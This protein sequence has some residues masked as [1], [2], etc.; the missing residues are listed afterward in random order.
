[1]LYFLTLLKIKPPLK[2]NTFT[3]SKKRFCKAGAGQEKDALKGN[4]PG[5]ELTDV[6]IIKADHKKTTRL[7]MPRNHRRVNQSSMD[8]L[9][10]W[11][12]NCDIQL[13][14][15][16][17]NPK[18]PNIG[19]IAR[20]TDYVVAYSCKGNATIQEE[21]ETNKAIALNATQQTNDKR[22]LVRLSKKIMN[23]CTK[24]RMI[25]KQEA[26][27]L[28]G[29]LDLFSCS[30]T[31]ESMSISNSKR[32]RKKEAP[33]QN[34]TFVD[35]YAKRPACMESSN[36]E[37]YFDAVSNKP[38]SSKII[39]PNF[40]GIANTPVYPP[41]ENYARYVLT[42]YKPW[43]TY[44]KCTNW[45]NVF[46]EFINSPNAPAS[47][48]IPY[49]R[50][51]M[52]Y[53]DKTVHHQPKTQQVDH[54]QNEINQDDKELLELCGLKQSDDVDYDEKVLQM[55]D[56]GLEHKWDEPAKVCRLQLYLSNFKPAL[57]L[58]DFFFEQNR[59]LV[60]PDIPPGLWLKTMIE[61][62]KKRANDDAVPES[63]SLNIPKRDDG[64][65][66]SLDLLKTDQ[67]NVFVMV[68]SKVKEFMES[69][70]LSTFTPLRA[71][72]N[73]FGGSGKSMVM[74]T[75]V[76]YMRKMFQYNDVIKIAAPTGTAAFNVGGETLHSLFN[77]KVSDH[78]LG[79]FSRKKRNTLIK[80]FKCLLAL[81]IDERSLVNNSDLGAAEQVIQEYLY[82]GGPLSKLD[83]GG[84]PILILVGDDYQ[85]PGVTEGPLFA[86]TAKGGSK[87]TY[88]GRQSVLHCA[89]FVMDLQSS[90]RLNANAMHQA[91]LLSHLRTGEELTEG[92]VTKLL[93]LHIDEVKKSCGKEYIEALQQDAVYLFYK[94]E[95]RIR[96]NF[97]MLLK[98]TGKRN[99]VAKIAPHCES[100]LA[101][102]AIRRHFD[103]DTP[104]TSFISKGAKVAIDEVNMYPMWGLHNGACGIV[105]EIIFASGQSP[106]DGNLPQYVVVNFPMYCGPTWDANNT[107]SV[108]IPIWSLT[109]NKGCCSR[110]WLPLTLAYART[111]HKFQGLTAG[112]NEPNKPPNMYKCIFCDPDEKQY[113]GTA[114]G[115]LYTA[116]SR[117][118]TLGQDN[119]K[120]SGIYF[121]GTDFKKSRIYNLYK[122]K[123]SLDDYEMAAKRKK[124]VQH[125][126]K[127][128]KDLAKMNLPTDEIIQWCKNHTSN[129]TKLDDRIS[130]YVVKKKDKKRKR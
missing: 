130:Q 61:Q 2:F 122:K 17:T 36:M 118:T 26:V 87:L 98:N 6:P 59:D 94:N 105:E 90:K 28:L 19:E 4:T 99:P 106:N 93:S 81:I 112:P 16:N 47:A 55:L 117:A 121:I 103:S 52:R 21:I 41:T 40:V 74:N 44:P 11:R 5:F 107:K 22:D 125:L 71:T 85:L 96:H 25:S 12:G 73:G 54:S 30:E 62:E 102:K 56:K 83:W 116:V 101:A 48:Q 3:F 65:E 111:I 129:F 29:D 37:E 63:E 1:M 100:C 123:N 109:C 18:E 50:A 13:L 64:S 119:G 88:K 20:V 110:H 34:S 38:G 86:L 27:V 14:V 31:I 75:I 24:K 79:S 70:D 84:L 9:Q 91:S 104:L 7:Y 68:M 115:L 89:E 51:M 77:I 113:E 66:Y 128:T 95:K 49:R 127:N 124:W 67:L 15:Y 60:I 69:D 32:L 39:I 46:H 108:P 53:I 10:S 76:S 43:R 35:K 45:I 97:E 114:I 57:I 72:V 120:N 92:D 8:L 33:N 58:T 126:A 23:D 82:N 42:A 80:K 78:D